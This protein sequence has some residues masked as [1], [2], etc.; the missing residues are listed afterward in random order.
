MTRAITPLISVIIPV[1]NTADY[2][3]RAIDSVLNQTYNN[4][5][6]IVVDDGSKDN[7]Y[8]IIKENYESNE[9]VKILKK[10]NGGASTARNMGLEY[11]AGDYITFLDS[12]DFFDSDAIRTLVDRI[13]AG[14]ADIAIPNSYYEIRLNGNTSLKKLFDLNG[15]K[16]PARYFSEEIIIKQGTAWRCSSVLYKADIIKANE[17]RFYEGVTAEDYIFNLSY[18]K[19]I[20]NASIVTKPTLYV[21][22]RVGSVTATYKDTMFDLYLLLDRVA[23]DYLTFI[24][25]SEKEARDLSDMLLL[26]NMV[27]YFT[28]TVKAK[29][30]IEGVFAVSDKLKEKFLNEQVVNQAFSNSINKD[31]HFS[32]K[33]KKIFAKAVQVLLKARLYRIAGLCVAII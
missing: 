15:K 10:D 11:A 6:I 22:K 20:N 16:I 27:V 18:F 28:K 31:M 12:D 21:Q 32:T 25:H 1:Y 13:D 24:G 33:S 2:V 23:Y 30:K 26:R 3:V 4:V 8:S 14:D 17:I 29:R 19:Y 5:E 9:K 7:S